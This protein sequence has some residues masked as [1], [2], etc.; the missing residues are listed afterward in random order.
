MSADAP[1]TSVRPRRR[2]ASQAVSMGCRLLVSALLLAPSARAVTVGGRPRGAATSGFDQYIAKHGRTYNKGSNEYRMRFD[3]FEAN[4]REIE[5]HNSVPGKSWRMG[6]NQ[7]TDR[8]SEE[9]KQSLGRKSTRLP[10]A[11]SGPQAQLIEA[12]IA[13]TFP[14]KKDWMHLEAANVSKDQGSCGSCWAFSTV[15][16]LQ[17]WHEIKLP[18][19]DVGEFSVQ[20]LVNCVENEQHCGGAGGCDGAT[21]ELAMGYVTRRGISLASEVEYTATTMPCQQG[22]VLLQGGKAG[23]AMVGSMPA[24]TLSFKRLEPNLVGQVLAH[25]QDSPVA[26]SVAAITWFSYQGGI[27]DNC[28]KDVIVDHAVLLY[29]YGHDE[30]GNKYWI[31][32]NS[33]GPSYGENGFIRIKRQDDE[34][35][36][37]GEDVDNYQGTGCPDKDPKKVTVC[38]TCGFLYDSVAVMGGGAA[39]ESLFRRED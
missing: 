8:T 12:G 7:W 35:S 13:R 22:N 15:N 1:A 16:M 11:S 24:S 37:C 23:P 9:R 34:D 2:G 17:A 27:F 38:G 31:I 21:V 36:Y 5:A 14:D 25:V 6:V 33:W 10:G 39:V 28:A 26:V 20:E 18:G 32:K 4:T 19:V 29:G 3:L 30:A